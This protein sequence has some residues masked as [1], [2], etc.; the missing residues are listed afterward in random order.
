MSIEASALSFALPGVPS[1]VTGR[2]F[3]IPSG[4]HAAVVGPYGSGCSTLLDLFFGVRTPTGGH[5]SI[6]GMDIRSWYLEALREEVL[7][8][9]GFEIVPG[10]I[11][12]NLRLGTRTIGLDEIRSALAAVGLLE[13]ILQHPEGLNLELQSGGA[14][15]FG[16]EKIRLLLARALVQKPRLLLVDEIL[17]GVDEAS[18]RTFSETILSP[19][20]QWTVVVASR[21]PAVNRLFQRVIELGEITHSPETPELNRS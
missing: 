3:A 6:D 9:R 8:L 13:S 21:D 10:T 1:V 5:L 11:V 14:P 19:A 20:L 18:L 16:N 17:D 7:L 15:L 2:T 12:Q 4:G